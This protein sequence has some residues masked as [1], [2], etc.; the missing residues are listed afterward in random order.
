[1]M[2][3]NEYQAK[4]FEKLLL[5]QRS[6]YM[7]HEIQPEDNHYVSLRENYGIVYVEGH[8]FVGPAVTTDDLLESLKGFKVTI[9]LS[10]EN[11]NA[12]TKI[13]DRRH[14]GSGENITVALG[15]LLLELYKKDVDENFTIKNQI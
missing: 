11:W 15:N 10:G 6:F 12:E 8:K 3:T 5:F 1:M 9:N 7:W 2:L 4:E 14:I 13:G